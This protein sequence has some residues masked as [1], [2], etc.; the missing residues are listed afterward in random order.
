MAQTWEV[1]FETA[2]AHAG[3]FDG[4]S[5]GRGIIWGDENNQNIHCTGKLSRAGRN[6]NVGIAAMPNV[7]NRTTFNT[8]SDRD[9]AFG[10]Q[11]VLKFTF[12]T[13]LFVTLTWV[14]Y[15]ISVGRKKVDLDV[16]IGIG[17][18][19]LNI[20]LNIDDVKH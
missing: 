13:L 12:V 1:R 17:L 6:L 16:N 10:N 7:S 18:G 2:V 8:S 9:C 5:G 3:I 20:T 15:N 11:S 14:T 19:Y 4:A